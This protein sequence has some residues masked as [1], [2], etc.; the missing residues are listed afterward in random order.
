MRT[1][2]GYGLTSPPRRVLGAGSR[3]TFSGTE[4]YTTCR[5]F[6]F[7]EVYAQAMPWT[8]M[9]LRQKKMFGECEGVDL[10]PTLIQTY[11]MR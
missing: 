6:N 1:V 10:G 7:G 5:P 8:D 3:L 9:M 2:A 4:S 11:A